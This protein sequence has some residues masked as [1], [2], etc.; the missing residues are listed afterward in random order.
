[1]PRRSK[2]R[3]SGSSFAKGARFRPS[4][5][6]L[7]RSD[8]NSE[9]LDKEILVDELEVSVQDAG[10]F[11]VEDEDI[12]LVVGIVHIQIGNSIPFKYICNPV[13]YVVNRKYISL[14]RWI[15]PF[16]HGK[17]LCENMAYSI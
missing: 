5:Y 10:S 17:L 11:V 9:G 6:R 13:Y 8:G 16:L 7:N 1:V 4:G 3:S 14:Y 15:C 2:D 12:A